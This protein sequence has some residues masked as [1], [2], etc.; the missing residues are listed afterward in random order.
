Y[1]HYFGEGVSV[2]GYTGGIDASDG[3]RWYRVAVFVVKIAELEA[4]IVELPERIDSELEGIVLAA[5]SRAG[6]GRLRAF[7]DPAVRQVVAHPDGVV[8][9][10]GED[11][12]GTAWIFLPQGQRFLS[13]CDD[14]HG[15]EGVEGVDGLDGG[16]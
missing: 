9:V 5:G 6:E 13:R 7:F 4:D 16:D 10:F 12:E 3:A 14:L 1:V 8:A 15:I 11:E 2:V